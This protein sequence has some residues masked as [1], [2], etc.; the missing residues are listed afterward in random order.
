M[1][2][3]KVIR[4]WL[5]E[6]KALPENEIN[7]YANSLRQQEELI[8]GL[9]ELLED[10][11]V[12]EVVDPVCHQ[13]FEFYRTGK[14]ELQRFTLEFVPTLI[15]VYLLHIAHNAKR[16]CGGIEVCLL[17]IYNLEIVNKDGSPKIHTFTIPTLAMPSIYH[18][19]PS[20]AALA[21]TESVLMRYHSDAPV[22]I[23]TGP[24]QQ[25]ESINAQNRL[26]VLTHVLSLYNNDIV[27]LSSTSRYKHCKMASRLARAGYSNLEKLDDAQITKQKCAQNGS[28]NGSQNGAPSP[29]VAE[30][31]QQLGQRSV[32]FLQEPRICLSSTLLVEMLSGVYFAM[33]NGLSRDAMTA[34]EDIHRRASL[35]LLA[36]VLLVTNGIRNSLTNNPS[37]EPGDGPIGISLSLSPTSRNV[38]VSKSAITNASFRTKKLPEDIEVR[39][40]DEDESLPPG[41][42]EVV[43]SEKVSVE[44]KVKAM[45]TK[46]AKPLKSIMKKAENRKISR[47]ES[48]VRRKDLPD[49]GSPR[50]S[51]ELP[52]S[53]SINGDI[54]DPSMVSVSIL[55]GNAHASVDHF[56]TSLDYADTHLQRN[57]P[58]ETSFSFSEDNEDTPAVPLLAHIPA[59]RV[60]I[61]SRQA[62]LEEEQQAEFN[63]QL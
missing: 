18:E 56:N 22:V 51:M 60:T 49:S 19:P 24:W 35:H 30:P 46:M 11:L 15:E 52:S 39:H 12:Q 41:Y 31:A 44:D 27:N 59:T 8:T 2:T 1:A 42:D 25:H 23:A 40:E 47:R 45:G 10:E 54:T 58:A 16:K 34:L 17:G 36:D 7:T 6:Y 4:D 21:L 50:S 48:D 33:F 20:L 29:A 55:H 63:T 9:Y 53:S 13:L 61:N 28:Q 62:T 3:S 5:A 37:G 32:S 43:E 57:G 38:N 26:S 14:R